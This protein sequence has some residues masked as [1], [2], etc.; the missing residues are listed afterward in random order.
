LSPIA[1]RLTTRIMG[2]LLA[3]I[4]IKF[5]FD[6]LAIQWGHRLGAG[7]S[8]PPGPG[9]Q[10]CKSTILLTDPSAAMKNVAASR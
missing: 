8:N 1:L 3:A 4:A 7:W 2:L 9:T 5:A 10:S 6:A